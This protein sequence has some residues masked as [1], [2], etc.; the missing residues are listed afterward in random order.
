MSEES[1]HE[2]YVMFRVAPI[3]FLALV[4]PT[5][6]YERYLEGKYGSKP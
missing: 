2:L 6:L 3:V 5:Y 4:L 1:W